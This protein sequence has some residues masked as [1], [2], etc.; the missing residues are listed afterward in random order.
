MAFDAWQALFH[1]QWKQG[2]HVALIGQTGSG[3]TT[4]GHD[5][6]NI[7]QYVVVLA[8]KRNDDVLA[9]FTRGTPKYQRIKNWPPPYDKDRVIL[10]A[11]PANLKDQDQADRVYGVLNGVFLAGGWCVFLDDTGYLTSILGLKRAIAVLLNQGRSSG[12]SVVSVMTQPTSVV[13]GIPTETLRQ[14]RYLIAFKYHD[15]RDIKAIAMIAGLDWHAVSG[16][17]SQLGEHDFLFFN[18]G[19]VVLVRNTR[20]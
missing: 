7:R 16:Y 13:Q 3:K 20:G 18:R 1:T 9:S 4:L 5:I 14:I 8:V 15:E 10:V 2:E 6:L 17:M 19:G 11:R 12:I